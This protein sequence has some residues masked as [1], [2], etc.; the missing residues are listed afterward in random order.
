MVI[1]SITEVIPATAPSFTRS[2]ANAGPI[3]VQR[4]CYGGGDVELLV[5]TI[6]VSTRATATYRIVQTTRLAR[7]PTGMSRCGF[8]AS[9]AAV[10]MASKPI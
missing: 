2:R 1:T 6:P 3:L 10:E 4:E 5:A 8:L 9:W 7:I